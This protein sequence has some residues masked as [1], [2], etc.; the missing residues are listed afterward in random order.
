MKTSLNGPKGKAVILYTEL[1]GAKADIEA[2]Q[3]AIKGIL[4]IIKG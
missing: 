3:A 1:F 2:F 4:D